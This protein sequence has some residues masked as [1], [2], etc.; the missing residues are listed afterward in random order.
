MFVDKSEEMCYTAAWQKAR[1]IM[2]KQGEIQMKKLLAILLALTFAAGCL[3]GCG[4]NKTDGSS[5]KSSSQASNAESAAASE[6]DASD[7]GVSSEDEDYGWG[8]VQTVYDRGWMEVK[9]GDSILEPFSFQI[10]NSNSFKLDD[11]GNTG[12]YPDGLNNGICT[13]VSLMNEYD[14]KDF[15]EKNLPADFA[16]KAAREHGMFRD[17]EFQVI[18]SEKKQINGND[19]IRYLGTCKYDE[20]TTTFC[21]YATRLKKTGNVLAWLVLD[22]DRGDTPIKAPKNYDKRQELINYHADKMA[23]SFKYEPDEK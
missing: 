12:V 10:A 22:Y 21:A 16:K 3:S 7:A 2:K 5:D 15:D 1:Q 19:M 14:N 11:M 23:Q 4:G 17:T 18:S 9:D 8:D 13:V 20:H 6:S